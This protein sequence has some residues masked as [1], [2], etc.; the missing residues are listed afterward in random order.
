M[1][2]SSINNGIFLGIAMIISTYVLY[3]ANP[4]MFLT[5]R[6]VILLMIFILILVKS[7]MDARKI[8]GGFISFGEAFKNMFVTGAIGVTFCTLFEFI[9]TNYIDPS[10]IVMQQEIAMEA[11]EQVKEM[12][13]G[14]GMGEELEEEMD[15]QL[16]TLEETNP[17][18]PG[19]TL[20]NLLFRFVAP[21]AFMSALFGLIIKK[22]GTG[23]NNPDDLDKKEER[24]VINK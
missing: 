7:G 11:A 6:S 16:E 8:Q 15:K 3:L 5:A 19:N 4:S 20:K 1:H 14:F 17:F 18:S 24:Y 10:L 22:K 21:V 13:G 9:L 12:F 23:T 2:K